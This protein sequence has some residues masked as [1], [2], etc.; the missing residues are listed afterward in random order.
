MIALPTR[1]AEAGRTAEF[2]ARGPPCRVVGVV[3]RKDLHPG[4]ICVRSPILTS[5]TSWITRSETRPG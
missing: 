3:D 5:T 1:G 2:K 4:P